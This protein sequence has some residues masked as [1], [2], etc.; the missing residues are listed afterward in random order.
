MLKLF[1]CMRK[2]VTEEAPRNYSQSISF[3][4]TAYT[5]S[6]EWKY[7]YDSHWCLKP[8]TKLLVDRLAVN[9]CSTVLCS[10]LLKQLN[11]LTLAWRLRQQAPLWHDN[12]LKV[13]TI[14]CHKPVIF[15]DI[16]VHIVQ[17]WRWTV[18]CCYYSKNRCKLNII[19]IKEL[20][21]LAMWHMVF[22]ESW[23]KGHWRYFIESYLLC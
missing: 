15:K 16:C 23:S 10:A 7:V 8:S 20:S 21:A 4:K 1:F 6:T 11:F 2:G 9:Y 17:G 12:K 5:S 14:V 13:M 19:V 22:E 18:R 3:L